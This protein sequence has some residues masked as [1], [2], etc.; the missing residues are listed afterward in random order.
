MNVAI[1]GTGNVGGTLGRRWAEE[2][3]DIIFGSRH[4]DSN[5]VRERVESIGERA[6]AVQPQEA[7]DAAEIV[8]LATP[9]EVTEQVVTNLTGLEGKVVVDCTNPLASDLSGLTIGHNTS[10]AEQVVSWAPGARVVKAFNTTGSDNMAD[11]VYEGGRLA[12]FI[13]GDDPDAKD[14]VAN[15]AEVL[16][17]E[18]VDCGPLYQARYLE[19]LAMLWISLAY[20]EGRGPNFGLA[21]LER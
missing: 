11:P 14:I 16:G 9:W 7:A 13:C 17:F 20:A 1:I 6:C 2:G 18:A 10:G 8:V 21:L 4:P 15:M 12:M 3:Y 19:P 5:D